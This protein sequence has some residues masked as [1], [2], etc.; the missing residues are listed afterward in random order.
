MSETTFTE[1]QI[2]MLEK[3]RDVQ[4]D[5]RLRN[6]FIA[7]L[8]LA[9]G[10]CLEKIASIIGCNVKTVKNWLDIYTTEGIESLNTFNYKPKKCYLGF[11]EVNQVIIYVIF[12]S[13]RNIGII[14][15][16]IEN[17]F[18]VTYSEETVRQLLKKHGL[19]YF[20]PK[21]VPGSP[22][23]VEEQERF[24]EIY[25]KLASLPRTRVFFG[26]A[27]H[28][29]HQNVPAQCWGDPQCPPVCETNTGRKRLNILGA[30]DPDAHSFIH[31]TGEENC[32][33]D[34]VIQFL[35]IVQKK[36]SDCDNI[37]IIVDNAS[38]F[39]A[40]KVRDWLKVNKNINL[41]FLPPYSP[42]LNLIE[43]FWRFAKDH[44]VKNKYYEKYKTFRA[45]V[46]RF[47]NN[48]E[49]HIEELE[50]LMVKKF[51]IVKA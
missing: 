15:N 4:K 24:I 17:K 46:F 40:E 18:G 49:D 44:L 11:H 14:V 9:A 1:N 43:C 45:N 29:I 33:A 19:K 8:M 13:P 30:Y 10:D 22:P 51:E 25:F 5:Y 28:L 34:R 23:S 38:Y 35:E 48:I 12:N 50:S 47:L 3:Y 37:Y 42:N 39:Y 2:R 31:L 16:Y 21:T 20:R 27:M 26:D 7:L 36:N 6:R 32:N 41:L